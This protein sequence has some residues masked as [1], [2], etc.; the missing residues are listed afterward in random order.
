VA[1]ILLAEFTVKL[2]VVPRTSPRSPQKFE[3][4]IVTEVA[5]GT[6]VQ[7]EPEMSAPAVVTVKLE[8]K[9]PGSSRRRHA[10]LPGGRPRGTVAVILLA[11]LR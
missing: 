9:S 7:G 1:V 4:L 10:D 3:P 5:D 11:G 2:A 6:A 8:D